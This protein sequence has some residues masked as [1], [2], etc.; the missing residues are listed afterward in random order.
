MKKIR[1]TAALF[2]LAVLISCE[3]Y[4]IFDKE[5][6]DKIVYVLTEGD[7]QVFSEVHS[8]DMQESVG[9]VVVLVSG[10]KQITEPIAVEFEPDPEALDTYNKQMFGVEKEKYLDPLAPS[11]YEIS[12]MTVNINPGDIPARAFLPIKIRP[13][14]LSPDSTYYIPLKIKSASIDSIAKMH[15]S[16][17]YQVYIKNQYADQMD[18]TLYSMRG[19]R[20]DP[21][22][23]PYAIM[24]NKIVLP[25]S[26][27]K[28]RTTVDQKA[29]ESKMEVI[30]SSC[31][32]IEIKADNSLLI[33]SFNSNFLEIEM[34]DKDGYNQYKKDS[35]GNN[36][37]YLSYRY[38]THS[39]DKWTEWAT[40]SENLLRYDDKL[41]E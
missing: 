12:S 30:N 33:T 15:N 34:V 14:G 24:T 18:Q 28:I 4:E 3:G 38:R 25:I 22:K 19:E 32:V 35:A 2:C 7:N 11:H 17:M 9:N 13:E 27:N 1:I 23:T 39:G 10:S 6:Y 31:M 8:L 5:V 16:V 40:I 29:F 36:R 26:K 41:L 21:G 37:F 20:T